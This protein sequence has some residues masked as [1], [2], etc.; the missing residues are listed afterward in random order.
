MKH[1]GIGWFATTV[2][3]RQLYP[4]QEQVGEAIIDSVLRGLGHTFTVMFA[5]QMGKNETSAIIE[6]YLLFCMDQGTLVKAAPTFKP[7][8]INSRLRLLEPGSIPTSREVASGR[9][10]GT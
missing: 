1:P 8:I 3:G 7:Q 5:R 9:A 6:S 4:Y 2:L 10:M